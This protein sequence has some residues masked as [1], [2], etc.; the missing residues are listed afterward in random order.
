MSGPGVVQ[1]HLWSIIDWAS[2]S[3]CKVV[4]QVIRTVWNVFPGDNFSLWLSSFPF[5]S[6]RLLRKFVLFLFLFFVFL[7][8]N[9]SISHIE[10]H[11]T[12]VFLEYFISASLVTLGSRNK[13]Q[14]HMM[15]GRSISYKGLG[16]A[17][18]SALRRQRLPI[19]PG[20]KG[21]VLGI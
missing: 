12:S 5:L 20:R 17:E 21:A 19:L 14:P 7:S 2:V 13:D 3:W 8:L 11:K 4:W 15:F 6:V 10:E 9:I 16:N 1:V 18:T